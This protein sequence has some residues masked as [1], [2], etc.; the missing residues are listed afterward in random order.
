[1]ILSHLQFV[2]DT[3]LFSEANLEELQCIK[4]LLRNFELASGLKVNFQKS[5]ICGI[6][7]DD[8]FLNKVARLLCCKVGM[9]PI[10]YLG[11]PLGANP[12]SLSTWEPVINKFK[13]RLSVWKR[14]N[15]SLRGRLILLKPCLSNL[16]VY[17][18]SLYKVPVQVCKELDKLQRRF[19]W[20]GHQGKRKMHLISWN[21]IARDKSSGGWGITPIQCK[22]AALLGK[23]WWRFGSEKRALW[24]KVIIEKCDGSHKAWF[25]LS[26][27]RKACSPILKGILSIA[28]ENSKYRSAILENLVIKVG[29]GHD[30]LFWLD[31]WVSSS[32]FP[33]NLCGC[34]SL[35][36][37]LYLL[38]KSVMWQ[39]YFQ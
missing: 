13:S 21:V 26:L 39:T 8:C 12:R 23:W 9:L 30:I 35:N 20:G 2:D 11:L 14:K 36:S 1:M 19:L 25:P 18:M 33:L 4:R 22:N 5:L 28:D 32:G 15:L 37:F 38:K 24:R 17:Y 31:P 16:P 34:C 7:V 10:S 3:I 6:G 29:S 27:N